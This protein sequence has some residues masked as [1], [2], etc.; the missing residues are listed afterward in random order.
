MKRGIRVLIA[1]DQPEVRT[2]M[3]DV[4]ELEGCLVDDVADGA[5]ALRQAQANSPDLVILDHMMPEITGIEVLRQ[6]RS[7]GNGI[8]VIVLTAYGDD[9]TTWAGWAAGASCFLDKPF[10]RHVLLEWVD[11]LVGEPPST[12]DPARFDLGSHHSLGDADGT[13]TSTG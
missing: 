6:L 13:S 11:R 4:L 9:E 3:R 8:P 12:D 10:D 5:S 2:L 7:A 1:D